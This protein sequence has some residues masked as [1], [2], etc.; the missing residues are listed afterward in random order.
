V[1]PTSHSLHPLWDK[2]SRA[3]LAQGATSV[4]RVL[5]AGHEVLQTSELDAEPERRLAMPEDTPVPLVAAMAL[6]ATFVLLLLGWYVACAVA[7]VVAAAA[8]AWWLWPWM[9]PHQALSEP[10]PDPE[11]VT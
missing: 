9:P 8:I 6:F 4:D 10:V 2:R 3:S 7:G 1:I 11:D 5:A